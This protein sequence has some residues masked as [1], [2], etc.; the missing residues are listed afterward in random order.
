M[1]RLSAEVC[2]VLQARGD[3]SQVFDTVYGEGVTL[4]YFPFPI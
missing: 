1:L 2:I 4:Y 3:S